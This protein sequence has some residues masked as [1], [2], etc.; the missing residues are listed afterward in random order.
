MYC[1]ESRVHPDGFNLFIRWID[2][3]FSRLTIPDALND[4]P[5][6]A[7]NR[8]A[9]FLVLHEAS[10]QCVDQFKGVFRCLAHLN[11]I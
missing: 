7:R 6:T 3:V 11:R 5:E 9:R 10:Y 2:P 1:R 8:P 4:D